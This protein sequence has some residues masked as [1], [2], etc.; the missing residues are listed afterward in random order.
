MEKEQ[1]LRQLL[2]SGLVVV[3]RR[4]PSAEV[5]AIA[6]ALVDGG[7]KALEITF[8]SEDAPQMIESL[9]G[10]FGD[11]VLVGAGTVLTVEQTKQAV[12]CGVDFVFSPH[13]DHDV[14][15][16]TVKHNRISIPG[17][18][19]PTEIVQ[20]HRSGADLIKVFPASVLGPGYFKELRGPLPHIRLMPTG[21]VNLDNIPAFIENGAVAVG[22]GG[23]LLKP[24]LINQKAYDQLTDLASQ[25][26][27]TIKKVKNNKQKG[28]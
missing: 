19:T 2:D 1:V 20:A 25:F 17:A 4:P 24:D 13:Y 15:A 23:A 26:V 3:V 22:V 8:D 12:D 21:G 11:K 18:M 5:E 27:N 10:R 7:V 28:R 6:Q 16:E 9:K 14:V